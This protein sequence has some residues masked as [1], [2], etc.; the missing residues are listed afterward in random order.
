M[1]TGSDILKTFLR[2]TSEFFKEK[3]REVTCILTRSLRRGV[4]TACYSSCSLALSS[5]QVQR[6][7]GKGGY[8][9]GASHFHMGSLSSSRSRMSVVGKRISHGSPAGFSSPVAPL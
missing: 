1:T 8:L 5:S 6:P 9:P 4:E 3:N 7:G 2:K